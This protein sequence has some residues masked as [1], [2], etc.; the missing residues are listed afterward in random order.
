MAQGTCS[1]AGCDKTAVGRGWCPAHWYRWSKYGDPQADR[2]L[3]RARAIDH[4]D[5][6]RTCSRCEMRKPLDEFDKVA[7]ATLGRRSDCK[8]CRS[9]MMKARYAAKRDE[10][11]GK[12]AARHAAHPEERRATDRKR[13][14]LPHRRE[15]ADLRSARRR[16]R[17]TG[18]RVDAGVTR[19]NLRK[20][21]GDQCF[22]CGVVMAFV[23]LSRGT[24]WPENLATIEHVH[25]ISLGGTHTWDNVV[26]ACWSCN[27]RK[28]HTPLAEWLERK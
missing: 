25:P 11:R 1:I 8:T 20:Q 9:E 4:D 27:C 18:G 17:V 21:Y 15:R 13:N 14:A 7:N 16:A 12:M 3:R 22:Y 2:P 6:T 24:P 26:L 28:R 10:I 23:R 19:A 5:T